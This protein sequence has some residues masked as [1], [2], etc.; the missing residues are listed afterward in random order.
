M[1]TFLEKLGPEMAAA[2]GEP[3]HPVARYY[4]PMDFLLYLKEDCSY[5]ADRVDQ[6]LTLLW[7]PHKEEL[8]GI[9][10]KGLRVVY[11]R[12]RD[13]LA[14]NGVTSWPIFALL[15]EILLTVLAEPLIAALEPQRRDRLLEKYR[16][17]V[18]FAANE[19]A[20]VSSEEL[21]RAA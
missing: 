19:N 20:A 16:M 9:K 5:R 13:R 21:R 7:H 2:E 14:A 3:F 4:P 1:D 8:V 18:Q 15:S 11:N 10:L 6:F 17:A 12:S